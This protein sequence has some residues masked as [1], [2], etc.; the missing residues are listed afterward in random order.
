[1]NPQP[2][3]CLSSKRNNKDSVSRAAV[4]QAQPNVLTGELSQLPSQY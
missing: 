3:S 2:L 4:E 1:M